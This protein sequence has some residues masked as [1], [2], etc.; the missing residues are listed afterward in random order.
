ML[1]GSKKC[2][3]RLGTHPKFSPCFLEY[4]TWPVKRA[5]VRVLGL[6]QEPTIL[7]NLIPHVVLI[8]VESPIPRPCIRRVVQQL[9]SVSSCIKIYSCFPGELRNYATERPRTRAARVEI[10]PYA[11]VSGKVAV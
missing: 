6:G 2:G 9:V 5:C 1:R 11:Q 4:R 7:L 3:R 8:I 10:R